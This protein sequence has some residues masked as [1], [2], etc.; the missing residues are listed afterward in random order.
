MYTYKKFFNHSS[1]VNC[2]IELTPNGIAS[3]SLDSFINIY[4]LESKKSLYKY[5]AHNNGVFWMDKI[6]KNYII[7]SGEDYQLKIWPNPNLNYQAN[8]NSN[9]YYS[10]TFSEELSIIPITMF[11]VKTKIKKFILVKENKIIACGYNKMI[12]LKYELIKDDKNEDNLL[13]LNFI[14]KKEIIIENNF[15]IDFLTF[16]NDKKQE[17]IFYLG[18]LQVQ[19]FS[20]PNLSIIYEHLEYIKNISLNCLTQINND[21]IIYSSGIE[22]RIFNIKTFKNK[23]TYKNSKDITSLAK[24]KDNTLLIST[25]SGITRIET[26]HFEEISLISMIYSNYNNYYMPPT[27]KEKIEYIYIFEDGKIGICSS[28]GNIKIC[29]FNLA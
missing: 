20:I 13:K 16:Q 3:C 8:V 10:V 12:L 4:N 29:K 5:Q 25:S 23:F 6:Y 14:I 9:G 2:L 18:S 1:S 17:F 7:S 21:E 15:V 28:F 26:K 19:I 24:L 27:E 11:D 22:I